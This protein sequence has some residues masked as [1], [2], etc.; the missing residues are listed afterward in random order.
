MLLSDA[1]Q[2]AP[3]S[4]VVRPECGQRWRP[5]PGRDPDRPGQRRDA[6]RWAAVD[7]VNRPRAWQS[8]QWWLTG[9]LRCP[10]A[11]TDRPD[12]GGPPG[13]LRAGGQRLAEGLHILAALD[14]PGT[15]QW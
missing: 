7:L 6:R 10:D 1:Q 8:C 15:C 2:V 14:L 9:V 3:L 11:Q 4:A 12:R 13:P 5:D